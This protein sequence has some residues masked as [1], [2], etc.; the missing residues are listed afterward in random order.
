VL[1]GPD[2]DARW[3]RDGRALVVTV[4]P[5]GTL[6]VQPNGR[7]TSDGG[8]TTPVNVSITVAGETAIQLTGETGH[9]R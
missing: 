2:G 9:V 4:L 1:A 3:A 6:Y 5:A 8:G 7:I